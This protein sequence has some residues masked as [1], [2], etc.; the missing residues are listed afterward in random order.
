MPWSKPH[1]P[2]K[3]Q[4][5]DAALYTCADRVYFFTIRVYHDSQPFT[6]RDLSDLV[7]D[8][9]RAEQELSGGI[10]Y[11]YC[12]MPDHVHV[13]LSPSHPGVSALTFVDRFKGRSTNRSW[14]VGWQGKL[15]QPRSYDHIVRADED[16]L[17]IADYILHNPVRKGLADHPE[18]WQWC[19]SMNPLPL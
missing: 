2:A 17:A 12:L 1:Q 18:Q 10:V 6:R 5:L 13:L 7:L 14:T 8:V 4:R 19:G 16:L 9:L 11:T 3:N 15:W